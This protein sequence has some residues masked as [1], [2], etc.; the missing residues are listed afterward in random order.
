MA[1]T[2]YIN[3]HSYELTYVR[4]NKKKANSIKKDLKQAGAR[5]RLVKVSKG[6]DIYVG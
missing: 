1:K 6:Y 3:G 2:M 5:V 4:V